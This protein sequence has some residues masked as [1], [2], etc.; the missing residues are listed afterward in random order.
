MKWL[1][2]KRLSKKDVRASLPIIRSA[3]M[4]KGGRTDLSDAD[5]KA[6]ADFMIDQAK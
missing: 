6:A 1:D 5:V 4:A 3:M 2:M